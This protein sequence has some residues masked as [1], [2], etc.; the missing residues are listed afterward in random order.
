MKNSY[1]VVRACGVS[2]VLAIAAGAAIAAPNYRVEAL[3][4]FTVFDEV[5][6]IAAGGVAVGSGISSDY[7]DTALVWD[8]DGNV[9]SISSAFTALDINASGQILLSNQSMWSNGT[10]TPVAVSLGSVAL[11]GLNDAGQVVG[12]GQNSLNAYRAF[13]WLNGVTTELPA[14]SGGPAFG[15]AINNLGVVVGKAANSGGQARAVMWKDGTVVDLGVLPGDTYSAATGVNDLGQ[16]VGVSSASGKPARGFL[17]DNGV[18]TELTGFAADFN[19]YPRAINSAGQVI[20]YAQ[21]TYTRSMAFL[22]S[23]GVLRDLTPV[24]GDTGY[25]CLAIDV[26]DAGQLVGT[27]G[28]RNLRLTPSAP[29]PDVGVELIG[30]ATSAYQGSP[31]SYTIKVSNVGA[32][33]ARGV[34]LTDTLPAGVTFVSA[35][36]S[37][38]S[39]NASLPLVCALGD[40]A[41]DAAATVQLTVIPTVAGGMM[42]NASIAMNDVDVNPLNDTAT[43]GVPVNALIIPADL[44]VTVS[45]PSTARPRTNITYTM[46]VKNNGPADAK[47]V[48]L[49]NNMA[50]NLYFVSSSTTH[51]SCGG[52]SC[53]LGTLTSGTTATVTVTVRPLLRG[54][55]TS[56]SS[57]TFGGTDNNTANNTATITTVVK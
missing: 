15:A 32:L 37:Q 29:A 53:S 45:G 31:Y 13:V 21:K 12:Y 44:S 34:T 56:K 42:N 4:S 6:A 48:T 30:S 8:V 33:P 46:T 49:T 17:W 54:T 51:G 22:W 57:L 27:C 35:V 2:A 52:V 9:S 23:N 43:L 36:P 10:V 11:T 18:M 47:T 14:L 19:V 25:G 16:V 26:N 39:C 55:Y 5:T 38:G 24:M 28:F 20:G 3:P 50:A 41:T 1:R 7:P 40:L